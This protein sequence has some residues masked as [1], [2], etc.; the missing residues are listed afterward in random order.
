MAESI[1]CAI[2]IA[3]LYAVTEI[4]YRDSIGVNLP[5]LRDVISTWTQNTLKK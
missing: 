2:L 3:W 1:F 5:A 4:A